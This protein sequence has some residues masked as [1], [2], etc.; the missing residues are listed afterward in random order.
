M[1]NFFYICL[2]TAILMFYTVS[3]GLHK[4]LPPKTYLPRIIQH[5]QIKVKD[6]F[7]RPENANLLFA[8]FTGK[9]EGISARTIDELK[10]LNLIFLLTPSGY[11]LGILFLC[12]SSFFKR[13]K[14][15]NKKVL[16][17]LSFLALLLPWQSLVRSAL[18]KITYFIKFKFKIKLREMHLFL[19]VFIIS[20]L[21]GHYFKSPLSFVMSFAYIGTF[22]TLKNQSK[23]K[24]ILGI[25]LISL[26]MNLFLAKKI[27][28]IAIA[29]GLL[30]SYFFRY[31]VFLILFYLF[32]FLLYP[33][34]WIEP[35]IRSFIL[36]NRFLTTE[37]RGTFISSSIFIIFALLIFFYKSQGK[38]KLF[39]IALFL[40]LHTETA[41]GP[42]ITFVNMN[43]NK[44]VF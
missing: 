15:K 2:T 31:V 6:E 40:F 17:L 10:K 22:S 43:I 3:M 18:R 38:L 24:L 4:T 8:L 16:T 34:N 32:S 12:I 30:I 1:K 33:S 13:L 21:F 44:T 37:L 20:F 7:K 35:I 26:I 19:I 25:F 14:I 42:V 39:Y 9:K 28:L 29:L 5:F 41:R 11:L 27:S 36:M 23:F